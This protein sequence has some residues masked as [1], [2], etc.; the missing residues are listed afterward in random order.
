MDGLIA[1]RLTEMRRSWGCCYLLRSQESES[2]CR[3]KMLSDIVSALS[4]WFCSPW[5]PGYRSSFN[6]GTG[7]IRSLYG[8]H[9]SCYVKLNLFLA[10]MDMINLA[11]VVAYCVLFKIINFDHGYGISKKSIELLCII[12]SISIKIMTA[13]YVMSVEPKKPNTVWEK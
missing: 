8:C 11:W 5:Q 9:Q 10:F 2:L 1:N 6:Q 4:T 13:Q 3:I 7:L 12:Q